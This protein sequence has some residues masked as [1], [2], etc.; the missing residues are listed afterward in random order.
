M[1]IKE[2]DKNS[3]SIFYRELQ[4]EG[5]WCLN[6]EDANEVY[7]YLADGLAARFAVEGTTIPNFEVKAAKKQ[8]DKGSFA[9]R[10]TALTSI[11]EIYISSIERQI[12]FKRYYLK[13]EKDIEDAKHM[14]EL[15]KKHLD[16]QK[17]NKYKEM[18]TRQNEIPKA[19]KK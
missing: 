16:I 8:L 2:I 7:S 1:F 5:F 13:S 11:G 12:A 19:R 3:F 14:E 10:I 6:S 18:L 17:I 9:D 4:K 15:F